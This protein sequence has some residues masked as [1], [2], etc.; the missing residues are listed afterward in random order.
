MDQVALKSK[1]YADPVHTAQGTR[2]AVAS[3]GGF[4][5]N[6]SDILAK[7]GRRIE[8]NVN[9]LAEH[10]DLARTQDRPDEP[11]PD[12]TYD[13]RRDDRPRDAERDVEHGPHA[14]DRR[15]T[16][17][18][19][20]RPAHRDD[21]ADHAVDR[22]DASSDPRRDDRPTANDTVRPSSETA[23]TNH[24]STADANDTDDKTTTA[25]AGHG[26]KKHK[27]AEGSDGTE[28][29]AKGAAKK[30]GDPRGDEAGLATALKHQTEATVAAL[31]AQRTATGTENGDTAGA[32]ESRARGRG[33]AGDNTANTLGQLVRQAAG[34]K[35]QGQNQAKGGD[36]AATQGTVD[37][38]DGEN[39]DGATETKAK[40]FLDA[41]TNA[42]ARRQ[43]AEIADRIGDG[44]RVQVKVTSGNESQGI[45]SK[46]GAALTPTAVTADGQSQTP[47]AQAAVGVAQAQ[48]QA[49]NQQ[50]QA[51]AQQGQAAGPQA[52][53]DAKAQAATAAQ[54][55]TQAATG[56][57]GDVP[58]TQNANAA[59]Q[60]NQAS[61]TAQARNA[62]AAAQPRFHAFKQQVLE[63]VN[64]HVA[65]GLESGKDKITI[66]LKPAELG[67]IE[68][69]MEVARD[70]RMV[71]T[72]T[73]DNRD[74]LDLLQRDS[75]DLAKALQDAGMQTDSG[76]LQFNLREQAGQ[77][78]NGRDRP[79]SG[80]AR[81]DNIGEPA[82]AGPAASLYGG[83][84]RADGRVD[85]RA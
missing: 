80:Q 34:E 26:D 84:V 42:K 77:G 75:R 78:R 14:D 2:D 43:A 30:P 51:Q 25:E 60:S 55:G 53:G 46:P 70:G 68:V 29:T 82:D 20:H 28:A 50:G 39:V 72:I 5:V 58:S 79:P 38:A 10:A 71:A 65:K 73:A 9:G 44:N 8:T 56:Q 74:T 6:F 15:D 85:I 18:E 32:K 16:R 31:L 19:D 4:S 64:V 11:R 63:Q 69:Q 57:G 81:I 1:G 17:A 21:G 22:R 33:E 40:N 59:G 48:T 62:E 54:T 45:V 37:N 52:I 27:K 35:A 41:A 66:N 61:Q 83:G 7:A 24:D 36:Q 23:G 76:N 67:R 12:E 13:A 49:Q 3:L 47:T